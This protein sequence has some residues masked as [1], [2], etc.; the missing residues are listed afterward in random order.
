MKF[1]RL[2]LIYKY[3]LKEY[4]IVECSGKVFNHDHKHR[5]PS[6]LEVEIGRKNND[7]KKYSHHGSVFAKCKYRFTKKR[8]AV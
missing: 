3:L 4:N 7:N 2:L 5:H 6:S 8:G 1:W